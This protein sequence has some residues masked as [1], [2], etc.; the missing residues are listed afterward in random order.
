MNRSLWLISNVSDVRLARRPACWPGAEAEG[1]AW[2]GRWRRRSRRRRAPS[3][4][5]RERCAPQLIRCIMFA[6][7]SVLQQ[8]Q[9]LAS[10]QLTSVLVLF[11]MST[12][13][14]SKDA[15]TVKHYA[16][17]TPCIAPRMWCIRS[18]LECCESMLRVCC[19][20]SRLDLLRLVTVLGCDR[21][22]DSYGVHVSAYIYRT[23]GL[24]VVAAHQTC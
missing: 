18:M 19:S 9:Y 5:P 4:A 24:T 16:L 15:C 14:P 6:E 23:T 22:G 8:A 21:R 11:S 2:G 13:D 7:E 1:G 12:L 17:C 10:L 3:S 20:A